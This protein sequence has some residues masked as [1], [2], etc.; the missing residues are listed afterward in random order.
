MPDNLNNKTKLVQK[1]IDETKQIMSRNIELIVERGDKIDDL[2]DKT[3]N[4]AIQSSR[5]K[6]GTNQLKNSV[7]VKN[8]K[9]ILVIS[10]V[11]LAV[12]GFFIF[13]IYLQLQD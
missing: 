10:L 1:Q 8:Y 4:L 2:V 9:V 13:A 12:T 6:R 7:C 5:F 11:L 3:E